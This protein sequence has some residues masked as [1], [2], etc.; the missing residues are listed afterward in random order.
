MLS[1]MQEPNLYAS[2]DEVMQLLSNNQLTSLALSKI[3]KKNKDKNFENIQTLNG[4]SDA[5]W[6]VAVL[7]NGNIISG[8]EDKTLIEWDKNTGQCL[9]T[10]KGHSG[11]VLC[12]AALPNG[13]IISGSEDKTLIKWDKNT[14]QCLKTLKGHS[15]R[16]RC[17]AVLPNGNIISG[18]DDKTL[19]EWGKNTGQCL[20]TLK[21][22][23]SLVLCVA[24]LPNGNIISGS[25]DNTL[26]EWDKNTGQCLKTLK[27][28]S[29]AVWCVAALPNGNIISGSANKTLIEWDKNTGQC[30]KTLKGHSSA[31]YCVAALPNGN[32]ISGSTDKTLI[33]WD[34]NTGQCL[35]TLKGHSSVVR[36]V[37]ALPNGNI[38]SGSND[39]MLIEWKS[40]KA[41]ISLEEQSCILNAASKNASLEYLDLS[42]IA[43]NHLPQGFERL[44]LIL[45]S[46]PN[47]TSLDISHTGLNDQNLS[48]LLPILFKTKRIKNIHIEGNNL[49]SE[50]LK[51]R[52]NAYLKSIQRNPQFQGVHQMQ[53][54]NAQAAQQIAIP[55]TYECP[56]S[57]QIMID[58]VMLITGQ[59]YEREEI[60]KWLLTNDTC[61]MTKTNLD[62]NK[63]CIP[64]IGL[65]KMI[66]D[67]LL[68][69]PAL[70]E[71]N[72]AS[73][74]ES[75]S[76]QKKLITAL[77]TNDK[78]NFDICLSKDPRF[79]K[80]AL[81]DGKNLLELACEKASLEI[82]SLTLKKLGQTIWEF[83]CI[84]NDNGLALFRIV[85]KRLG[86]EGAAH[87][88]K[89]LGWT[90]SDY[91][92]LLQTALETDDCKLAEI[93]ISLGADPDKPL[94]T[95]QTPLKCAYAKT[96]K[97]MI[98]ILVRGNANVRQKDAGGNDLLMLTLNDNHP[99]LTL[100]LLT[101]ANA[102]IDPN[103]Q[104]GLKETPLILAVQKNQIDIISAL[105]NHPEIDM[106][107]ADAK[108]STPLHAAAE[109]GNTV[110]V[111]LLLKKGAALEIENHQK[112]TPLDIAIKGDMETAKA[113][114]A[115]GANIERTD[116]NG[117]NIL[118]QCFRLPNMAITYFLLK[119]ASAKIK[120]NAQNNAGETLLMLAVQTQR[121]DIVELML[122]HSD[123]DIHQADA[124]G[125][126]A[127]HYCA[128]QGNQEIAGLLIKAG[129]SIKQPNADK[130]TPVELAQNYK[131]SPL[132]RWMKQE[133]QRIKL[134]PF[135]M[136][137]EIK[138]QNQ[139]TELQ[140]QS[141]KIEKQKAK[142]K[143]LKENAKK[144][145]FGNQHNF[146]VIQ[147][148][149]PPDYEVKQTLKGH[150]GAVRCVAALPNGNIIS[151]SSDGTLIEWDKNTGQSLKTL[152]GHSGAVR[153]IAA[154]PN[155]NII[156]GSYDNTLIEWDKNTGQCLKT[157]KGHSGYV[158]C[159][160]ALPNGNIISG[161]DDNTLIEWDKNTDQCLKTLKGHSGAVMCV[162][163]LPNGNIIS[164]SDDNTLIEWD[165]NTGQCLKTLKG[166]SSYVMCVAA[167]PNGNIISGSDDNTLIEWDKNTWQ[168]LKTLKGHSSYVMCVAALPNGNIISGSYDNTLIEW[169]KNTGQC[170][171]TLKGHSSH[172]NCVTALPNGNI[173][174]GSHDKTLIEWENKN[175]LEIK[176]EPKQSAFTYT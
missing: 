70:W 149:L 77:E 73:V 8:S 162:A 75:P 157:L 30:L 5:I 101:G 9:K 81:Q 45:N 174:S 43:L 132:A 106:A 121:K 141:A 134:A 40:P 87:F 110:I 62:G 63:T 124:K 172:V 79:L 76:L 152:K 27:G 74:Y 15:N 109:K 37:A 164:G 163:A 36:C 120:I 22:H 18:S 116:A 55:E 54:P 60:E 107:Q 103:T 144:A 114:I 137:L 96:Q 39:Y 165:K 145:E 118:M 11:A 19:I 4:H 143:K 41:D 35:K 119:E 155:G 42:H 173:I 14:G 47:L 93:S 97:E 69:H 24:V 83:P 127:L 66:G 146:F 128:L 167:L 58:P 170:L 67:F 48:E 10:L 94:T 102:K 38:I 72:P 17:V 89:T 26:I 29:G 32:I 161:S 160:A 139:Q 88:A 113:L 131:N 80:K 108:G 175:K 1:A 33:E 176:E 53:Q 126:T 158:W 71:E 112:Q 56:I 156:S 130:K 117:N 95:Q 154:L 34:K 65:K 57:H 51:I 46:H 123:I 82:L 169:D 91:Q 61:P 151:G 86:I 147:K 3:K 129:A 52:L 99:D 171:K 125:N 64:G 90:S 150:S 68:Q 98:K 104:N 166:H 16:V 13:N 28:H 115:A 59:S 159:V 50:N 148:T 6:C 7:P 49:L 153:C 168:C 85:S 133:H 23:S 92:S 44:K 140:N 136:P 25:Y 20:K 100:F 122:Q 21:E 78:N 135:L 2:F 105:L 142:I 138:L 12:V 84:Y 31:V 111:N